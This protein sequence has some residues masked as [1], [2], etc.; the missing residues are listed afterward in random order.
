METEERKRQEE[1]MK[2]EV[3][4]FTL[5]MIAILTMVTDHVGA[6]VLGRIVNGQTSGG[7]E[8]FLSL[9][10]AQRQILEH[11]YIVTRCIGRLS[12]PI[13][14]YL[15]VEGFFYTSNRKKHAL[16]LLIFALLSEIPFDL[17]VNGKLLEL[18]QHNN[19]MFTLFL[20][21]LG[22]WLLEFW[23]ERQMPALLQLGCNAVTVGGVYLVAEGI[24]C[25]Y[26]GAG[27]LA[28]L[29][30][31]VLRG[32]HPYVGFVLAIA[33][34]AVLCS[35]VE[36]VALLGFMVLLSYRG[37]QGR[38]LKYICYGVY[39]V[40]LLALAGVCAEMGI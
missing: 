14:C 29:G 12:F 23:K 13:F 16:R 38:K 18:R 33:I 37:K 2:N 19:V 31:Y 6:V 11:I 9:G 36:L 25:D 8:I 40:H 21:F 34:L 39:P 28:I 30:I 32:K 20:G 35:P 17:A 3:T 7:M 10:Q 1:I 27:I 26:G 4:A 22:I 24:R 15:L 5:K